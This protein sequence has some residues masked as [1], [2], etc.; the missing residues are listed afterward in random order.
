MGDRRLYKGI[1]EAVE[2]RGNPGGLNALKQITSM[3]AAPPPAAAAAYPYQY[4]QPAIGD[5][6]SSAGTGGG[7][8]MKK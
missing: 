2:S 6:A 8:V 3:S 4:A 5:Y 7:T 1:Q